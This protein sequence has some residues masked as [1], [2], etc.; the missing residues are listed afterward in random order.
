MDKLNQMSHDNRELIVDIQNEFREHKAAT[1]E[2]V[3][4]LSND[5]DHINNRNDHS[6]DRIARLEAAIE[7]NKQER[8]KNNI[9]ISGLMATNEMQPMEVASKVFSALKL[10]I[11]NSAFHAYSTRG[12]AFI[13]IAFHTFTTKMM[14]ISAMRKKKSLLCEEIFPG[15]ASNGRVFINDHLSDHNANLLNV[16]WRAKKEGKLFF[17]SSNG[18]KIRVKKHEADT[19]C[20]FITSEYQLLSI[21][22]ESTIPSSS[23]G[24]DASSSASASTSA[25]HSAYNNNQQQ[26]QH[27]QNNHSSQS[28]KSSKRRLNHNASSSSNDAYENEANSKHIAKRNKDENQLKGQTRQP[29][30][31]RNKSN[32]RSKD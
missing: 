14:V 9:R 16:A 23:L 24:D 25:S 30:N 13:I 20:T 31:N 1:G 2:I 32:T 6:D 28:N 15:Q 17:V 7:S 4:G 19:E 10:N 21:I 26:R 3:Q 11:N 5:I 27:R 12:K 22:E 29:L 8:L 18:G